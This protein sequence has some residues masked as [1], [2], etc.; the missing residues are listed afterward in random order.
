MV[1]D[2]PCLSPKDLVMIG[3]DSKGPSVQTDR[4]SPS[5]DREDRTALFGAWTVL[6]RDDES[7]PPYRPHARTSDCA[8][9]GLRYYKGVK[10]FFL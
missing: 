7:R 5:S 2:S 9:L 1:S 6:V 3:H 4:L 10:R 8:S